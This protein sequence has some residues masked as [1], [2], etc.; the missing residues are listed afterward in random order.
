[1]PN[2]QFLDTHPELND[3]SEHDVMIA[4]INDE[5]VRRQSME[6]QRL[7]LLKKKQALIAENKKKK[8][9]LDAL[10][11]EIEKYINGGEVVQK[12]FDARMQKD[13]SAA[14]QGLTS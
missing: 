13:T 5:H 4:R 1:V 12:V 6:E 9:E 10:D 7:G 2:E 14:S 3:V 8:D 11:K